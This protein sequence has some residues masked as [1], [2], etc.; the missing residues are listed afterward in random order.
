MNTFSKCRGCG[1]QIMWIRTKAGRN[2]PVDPNSVG[3]RRP[4]EGEK[5]KQKIVT[6]YGEVVSAN[7]VGDAEAEGYGYI[8]HFATCPGAAKF[9]KR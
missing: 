2:M 1:C 6:Q 5:A 3:Y 7:I 4:K 9:R 8:S